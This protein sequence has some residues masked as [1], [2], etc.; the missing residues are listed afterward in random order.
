[1]N[2]RTLKPVGLAL[3]MIGPSVVL[4]SI[5][6]WNNGGS[7]QCCGTYIRWCGGEPGSWPCTQAAVGGGPGWIVQLLSRPGAGES[8]HTTY[9]SFQRGGCQMIFSAC[10]LDPGSCL[11]GAPTATTC[12]DSSVTGDPDCTGT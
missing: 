2:M 10:G 3:A 8:G 7:R 12:I 4:G 9:K 11:P 6:C 5:P 1:M